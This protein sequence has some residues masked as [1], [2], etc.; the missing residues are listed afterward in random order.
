MHKRLF[1]GKRDLLVIGGVLALSLFALLLSGRSSGGE[2][3][4]ARNGGDSAAGE[5][6]GGSGGSASAQIS[7][8]GEVVMT[9]SLEEDQ[10]FSIPQRPHVH[11]EVR[12]GRCA[13][14]ASDCPDQIC[15]NTGFLQTPGQAAA[16]LP[17]KIVL[18]MVEYGED[19]EELDAIVQ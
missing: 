4:S 10:V 9:V 6:V 14:I 16:C 19:A 18:R 17:N 5:A 1:M 8:N 3:G 2:G 7:L 12:G 13:F 11:L 15:V